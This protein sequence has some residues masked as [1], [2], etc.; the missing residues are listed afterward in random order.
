MGARVRLTAAKRGEEVLRA[1]VQ[2]FGASGYAGTKTDEIARLAGVSQPY[3]IRLFGTKQ[4]LFLAALQSVCD[5]VEQTFRDAAAEEPTLASLGSRYEQ[6]LAERELLLVL[7]H[8]FSAS[9]EPAIG[10]LV[11]ERFGGIYRLVRDL[12]GAS[13]AE[14][15][16][17]LATGMLL[18]VMSAM[19]VVGPSAVPLPWSEEIS[20]T[21][22]TP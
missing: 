3:V 17:F 16:E 14:A 7:L 2:A 21:L 4:Q 5:R 12:T 18:T 8:G 20:A 15:R 11:R 9:G 10:D 22:G 13:P 6:F 1:A 19:Q